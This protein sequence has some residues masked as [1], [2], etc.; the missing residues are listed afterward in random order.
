MMWNMIWPVM[1][2][3]TSNV[4]YHISQKSTP[5]NVNAFGS[6]MVTYWV[7]TLTSGLL[8]ILSA[9]PQNVISELGKINGTAL[10][11]GLALV[12]L[13]TGFLFIYRAGWKISM[14]SLVANIT[15]ACLLVFVGALLYKEVITARQLLGM[16][17]CAVGLVLITH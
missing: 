1:V 11:L 14:A 17:V 8:F 2:V 7:A 5:S 6:L 16:A 4:F 10:T 3:V 15:L 12:G 9:K 13:E